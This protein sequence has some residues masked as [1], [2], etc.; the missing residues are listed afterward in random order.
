MSP[1]RDEAE[2][3][4]VGRCSNSVKR[5]ITASNTF[6]IKHAHR[7]RKAL[8]LKLTVRVQNPRSKS[9]LGRDHLAH[10]HLAKLRALSKFYSCEPLP[11]I[12][13]F[14]NGIGVTRLELELSSTKPVGN[15]S[16]CRHAAFQIS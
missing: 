9:V 13:S 8:V 3:M 2:A 5:R 7:M 10:R 11:G 14:K 6:L 12:K 16:F 15:R 1:T 4:Q